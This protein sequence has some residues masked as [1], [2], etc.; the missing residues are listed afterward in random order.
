MSIAGPYSALPSS[1]RSGRAETVSGSS[2]GMR[3]GSSSERRDSKEDGDW[4]RR[5]VSFIL[6]RRMS[7]TVNKLISNEGVERELQM[8]C[9]LYL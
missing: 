8:V 1:N 9:V 7:V 4:N 2:T 3:K 5:R 6:K